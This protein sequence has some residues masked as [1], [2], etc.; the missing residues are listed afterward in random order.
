MSQLPVID[1][2]SDLKAVGRGGM[3]VVYT[4]RQLSLNRIVAIKIMIA[5]T[6][7]SEDE[8]ARFRGEA[9]AVAKLQHPNIVQVYDSGIYEDGS[10][11]TMEFVEGES[12]A[13]KIAHEPQD[14]Q[15]AAQTVKTLA[16]AIHHAHQHGI[17]HR[18]L[19]PANVLITKDEQ[20]KIT[21]FG[22]AKQWN[23]QEPALTTT[24]RTLG[25][26]LY[27]PKEQALGVAKSKLGPPTDVYALGAT[28]YELLTGRP[29]FLGENDGETYMLVVSA[30]PVPPRRLKP[31]VPLDLQTICLKCLEKESKRRYQ[32]A[33]E[34]ADDLQAFLDGRAIAARPVGSMGQAWRWARRKPWVAGLGSAAALLLL[35]TAVL[36]TTFAVVF[37]RQK[38]EARTLA[39]E[40]SDALDQVTVE[41]D[42][43]GKALVNERNARIAEVQAKN[44]AK[45]SEQKAIQE[46][47]KT[48]YQFYI[49]TINLIFREWERGN[50]AAAEAL[51]AKC[52]EHLR[53]WEWYQLK[54]LC[55]LAHITIETQGKGFRQVCWKPDGTQLAATSGIG[56]VGIWDAA[57]HKKVRTLEQ[58]LTMLTVPGAPGADRGEIPGMKGLITSLAWSPDGTK[59]AVASQLVGVGVV[60]FWDVER[61][62]EVATPIKGLQNVWSVAWSPDGKR[63][64]TASDTFPAQDRYLVAVWEVASGKAIC[65]SRGTQSSDPASRGVGAV[66]WSPDGSQLA[67]PIGN[68]VQIIDAS[69]GNLGRSLTGHIGAIPA[70]AWGPDGR[71][72]ATVG[73]DETCRLWNSTTG[74]PI[75]AF[76]AHKG[77]VRTVSWHPEQNQLT[78]GGDD[79]L[80]RIWD[81]STGAELKTLRGHRKGV[82][83]LAWNKDGRRLATASDDETVKVWDVPAYQEGLALTGRVG[84]VM[85]LSW[86]RDGTHLAT[87]SLDKTVLIWDTAR[88][89][90]VRPLTGHVAAICSVDWHQST[91]RIASRDERG[92][93][94]V[95]NPDQGSPAFVA[96]QRASEPYGSLSW[97]PDGTLLAITDN[98]QI[99]ILD[100]TTGKQVRSLRAEVR[101]SVPTIVGFER[102]FT[103]QTRLETADYSS[104]SWSTDG[105]YLAA[106]TFFEQGK[107][108]ILDASSGSLVRTLDHPVPTEL[109][110]VSLGPFLAE[111]AW[112]PD[113]RHVATAGSDGSVKIWEVKSW[114]T[115]RALKLHS[116]MITSLSWSPDGKRLATA[117]RDGTAMILDVETGQPVFTIQA[118]GWVKVVSWSPDGRR[119]AT[120]ADGDR[121]GRSSVRIWDSCWTVQPPPAR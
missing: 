35:V 16:G 80:V 10:F 3:G 107:A 22:L 117:S 106:S 19:K 118:T 47:D 52:P 39:G 25:T 18:D 63:I 83:S 88:G 81:A 56:G 50:I 37:A 49:T 13:A 77:T 97:N 38:D 4:A 68:R 87:G 101:V 17:L 41:R 70:V 112:S 65:S 114:T 92:V 7:A 64:A 96:D 120:V 73:V 23:S 5:G 42:E 72:L 115:L 27:M 54:R 89:A 6:D 93:I 44:E 30:E 14:P 1:G 8:L 102:R 21:D 2:Y 9:E 108:V 94:R 116:E 48:T 40:K 71:T 20:L 62:R 91:N 61:G 58:F 26:L 99:R 119:I 24:G 95:W 74:Q 98:K 84:E 12:L 59:L 78:T 67:V 57:T 103:G 55:S 69:N 104:V 34:L 82:M 113:N 75:R 110:L 28:L 66:A 45:A 11:F 33:Q 36:G 109:S 31:D 85:S 32:T 43:K 53:H 90:V 15:W 46:R 100:G 51:L 111:V 76:K 79:N 60:K 121:P 29:P 86:S 105:K